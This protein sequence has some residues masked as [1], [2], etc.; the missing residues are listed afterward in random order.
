MKDVA[1]RTGVSVITVSR[2]V[3]KPETVKESTRLKVQEA[4]DELGFQTNYAAKALVSNQTRTIHILIRT[5]FGPKDSYVMHLIAG[6]SEVLSEHYYSFLIRNDWDFPYK[7]DGIIVMG[8]NPG[9]DQEVIEKMKVPVVLFGKSELEVDWVDLDNV[10]GSRTMM[11]YILLQGHRRIGFLNVATSEHYAAERLQGYTEALRDAGIDIDPNI[12]YD[13]P[14]D[15]EIAYQK[16]MELLTNTDVTALFC[17][18]DMIAFGALRAARE[19]GR[20]VPGQISIG[21]FDG[22]QYDAVAYPPLT[23]MRQPIYEIGRALARQL[24]KRIEHPHALNV[25]MRV[26]PELVIR[27]SI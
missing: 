22:F 16:A 26:D 8:L 24:L 19:L 6:I 12:L 15:E 18:T 23:T 5:K 20:K 9:E 27:E 7:C 11:E 3:N 1:K 4:M 21:G 13:V 17:A 14:H 25:Q 2:V 10:K